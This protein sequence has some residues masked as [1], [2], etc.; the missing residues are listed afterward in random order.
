MTA[1][2]IVCRDLFEADLSRHSGGMVIDGG[3][4]EPYLAWLR[5]ARVIDAPDAG[6]HP[7][8]ACLRE[9]YLEPLG[10]VS[11]LHAPLRADAVLGVLG[12]EATERREWRPAEVRFCTEVAGLVSRAIERE[13]RARADARHEAILSSISDAVIACDLEQKITLMNPMAEQLTGWPAS[14][15]IGRSLDEVLRVRASD[16]VRPLPMLG[17]D[18]PP[19]SPSFGQ[20]LPS[21]L[22]R[23]DGEAVSIAQSAS[24]V[25]Q[26]G[27]VTGLVIT[28]RDVREEEAY[29]KALEHQFRQLRS[30]GDAIPDLVFTVRTDGTIRYIQRRPSPDLLTPVEEIPGRTLADLFPEATSHEIL[31]AVSRAVTSHEVQTVEYALELSHGPQRFEARL[32][33][34]S[35]DEVTA[36]VRNVTREHERARLLEEERARL[37]TVL[38]STAASLYVTRMPGFEIEYVSESATQTLGF[39]ASEFTR[40]GFWESALHPDD[41]AR[42]LTGLA[43]LL[44]TGVHTHEYRHRHADGTYRWLRDEVRLIR[45]EQGV[46]VRAIGASFDITDRKRAEGRLSSSLELQRSVSEISTVLLSADLLGIDALIETALGRVA[47]FARADRAYI[48]RAMGELM[49]NTHEWSAEG[50]APQREHLQ[51]LPVGEFAFFMTPLAQGSPLVIHSVR[52][53]PPEARAE[54]ESLASQGIEALLAVP[55]FFGGQLQGFLGIDNPRVEDDAELDDLAAPMRVFGEV[56]AGGLKRAA[57]ERELRTLNARIESRVAQQRAMLELSAA[58][59]SA[60]SRDELHRMLNRRLGAVV[61]GDRVSLMTRTPDGRRVRI[62]LLDIDEGLVPS[63]GDWFVNARAPEHELELDALRSSAAWRALEGGEV[64]STVDMDVSAYPDWLHLREHYGFEHFVVVP[65][66][67]ADGVFGCFNVCYARREAL[68]RE[69]RDW[70]GQV[71]SL[72]GAHIAAHEAREAL[73][74]LNVDLEARVGARTAELRSSEERF[75]ELFRQAPQAMLIVDTEGKV[76]R[77]N[78]RAQ[79]LFGMGESLDEGLALDALVPAAVRSEHGELVREFFQAHE[80][81]AMAANRVVTALRLDGTSFSA[82]IGLVV[83][84]HDGSPF[85]VAGVSDVTANV[86]AKAAVDESLREKETMLREIHHRVKNNLQIISSLLMLQSEQMPSPEGRE[87]LTESVLRVR[88]MA[89]IHQQLYGVDSLEKIDLGDYARSLSESLRS[90]LMPGAR[91][92]VDAEVAE[93]TINN[94]VPLG[95]ILNELVTNA[96]KYGIPEPG[97]DAAARVGRAGEGCDVRVEIGLEAEALRLAVL[98][99]GPGLPE[100]FDPE[101]ATSLGLHLVRALNRQIRGEL[102]YDVDR[103]SRFVVTCPLPA[104]KRE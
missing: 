30:I 40:P 84:H 89:L 44:E 95:L 70:V 64:V 50:V 34:M 85:V 35:G 18:A 56:V 66:V 16:T 58:L 51:G 11:M 81:R 69:D 21:R 63:P 25:T 17:P 96:F 93:V 87:L 45:D 15:S 24:P 77:T 60:R 59:P 5:E 99:S 54:Q 55:L 65:L 68:T 53:L 88:S 91:L 14:E 37:Q 13:A 62:R 48:F 43:G 8:T 27:A 3:S 98:D 32:A 26:D 41:R 46:P 42:V 10:T 104:A 31:E 92:R 97:T 2:S 33:R 75:T 20:V 29:R 74:R 101:R 90:V 9:T 1:S 103:G 23:R 22:F 12:V 4:I 82:E 102:S 79:A 61:G 57:D 67:G 28:F 78:A 73:E 100:G 36:L 80:N 49:F 19:G 83:I 38:A 76:V 72:L 7:A 6:T 86:A 47:R 39:S 52:G 71:G 94:A